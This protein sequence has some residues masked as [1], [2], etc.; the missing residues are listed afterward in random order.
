[1][2]NFIPN[3]FLHL[4]GMTLPFQSDNADCI[5]IFYDVETSLHDGEIPFNYDV[6]YICKIEFSFLF[7]VGF[8][9]VYTWDT[10]VF[11]II[12]SYALPF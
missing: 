7:Y 8:S 9:Y 12:F 10:V 1:M 6:S 3:I 4:L 5:H 2:F 11:M